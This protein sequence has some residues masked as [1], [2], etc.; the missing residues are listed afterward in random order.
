MITLK[1]IKITQNITYGNEWQQMGNSNKSSDD[2]IRSTNQIT[3]G[4]RQ[5]YTVY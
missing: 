5:Y 3:E 4:R 2:T 1:K